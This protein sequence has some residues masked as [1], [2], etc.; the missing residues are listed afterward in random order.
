M[1]SKKKIARKLKF[2][3]QLNA[4]LKKFRTKDLF[5]KDT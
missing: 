5:V 4:K 1:K 3:G 2:G